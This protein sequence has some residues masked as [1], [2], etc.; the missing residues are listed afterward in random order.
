MKRIY[1]DNAATTPLDPAVLQAMQPYLTK[2][3]GNPSSLHREGQ[4]A[5]AAV[6]RSREVVAKAVGASID[7]IFFTSSATEANNW[8]IRGVYDAFSQYQ[9]EQKQ[10]SER[11]NVIFSLIEHPSIS[12]AVLKQYYETGQ[13]FLELPVTPKGIVSLDH[14]KKM[15]NEKTILV[16]IIYANNEIGTIQPIQKIAKIIQD[17]RESKKE[18]S[19]FPL[20]HI[21]AT[22]AFQYLPCDV[23]KLGVDFMT[24]SSHKIYGPKGAGA[25]YVR[26]DENW[27]MGKCLVGGNQEMKQRAGTENVPAIV[28]FAKAVELVQKY[29]TKETARVKKLRDTCLA[30][31]KKIFP[32][33]QINGAVGDMRLANNINIYRKGLTSDE[34]I[35]F[36]DMHGVALS[37]GSA[38]SSRGSGKTVESAVLQL[39]GKTNTISSFSKA[40]LDRAKN[41]LRIT[42]GRQTT[43]ADMK[44]FLALCKKLKKTL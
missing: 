14:L 39:L 13:E 21:D 18:K 1:L 37:S 11:P 41:S 28:G 3:F 12:E 29:Q 15:L 5:A 10:K 33:I 35:A 2:N 20:F 25:L 32:N 36:F 7:E 24:L 8:I 17:F 6:L 30:E 26:A 22:Q 23:T 38:C 31:L 4:E 27:N 16:S 40:Q 19:P 43:K 42:L 34:A 9:I 44:T